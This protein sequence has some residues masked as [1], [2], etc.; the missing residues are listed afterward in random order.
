LTPAEQKKL[1][2][3]AADPAVKAQ[4]DKD[5]QLGKSV[6]VTSTPCLVLT[7]GMRRYPMSGTAVFNYPL[8]KS[9]LDDQL[10]K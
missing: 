3:L 2:T 10:K 4:V 8:I 7:K 5:I 6:P 9:F 1:K